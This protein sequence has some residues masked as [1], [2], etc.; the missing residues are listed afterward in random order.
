MATLTPSGS[1][2]NAV[3][4]LSTARVD[5]S[6][7][8]GSQ[9]LAR[10]SEWSVGLLSLPGRAGLDLGL[11]LSY[12]SLVWTRSGPSDH[13]YL[14]FNE[15]NSSPSPGFRLGFATVQSKYFDAQVGRNVY[16]LITSSG[17]RVEPRQ[18]GASN[19]Y[20][21]ADSSYLQ[22]INNVSSLMVRTTD[23]TQMTYQQFENEWYVTQIKDRNGNYLSVTYNSQSDIST[24]TDTLGRVINFNYDGYANLTSIT[25]NWGTGVHTWASF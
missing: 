21:A 11:G 24:V 14:Y 10:D 22:L 8:A 9:L 25:Q 3:S 20:E 2:S 15:D 12:S 7:Q 16:M 1:V 5:P 19:V 4:S 17:S 23:G 18:V 13:P 6:N